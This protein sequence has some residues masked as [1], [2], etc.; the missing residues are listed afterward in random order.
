MQSKFF[1]SRAIFQEKKN[2]LVE[3][4][5]KLRAKDLLQAGVKLAKESNLYQ[6]AKAIGNRRFID[7]FSPNL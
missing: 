7:F 4:F 2:I 1:L 6:L 5:L 3:L